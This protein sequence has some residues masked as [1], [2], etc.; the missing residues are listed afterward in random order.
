MSRGDGLHFG[1]ENLATLEQLIAR[2]E[3]GLD[4]NPTK[5]AEDLKLKAEGMMLSI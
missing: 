4:D 2:V 3:R 5:R 1:N